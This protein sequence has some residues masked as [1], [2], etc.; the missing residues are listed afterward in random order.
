MR[1][2][3]TRK[4]MVT[5]TFNLL[6]AAACLLSWEAVA[7]ESSACPKAS[8]G[9]QRGQ[10]GSGDRLIGPWGSAA[11]PIFEPFCRKKSAPPSL[12]YITTL[13]TG[14]HHKPQGDT[15]A[16]QGRQKSETPGVCPMS[17][18]HYSLHSSPCSS[19]SPSS[20]P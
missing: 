3:C 11:K 18:P 1:W 19:L 12:P 13:V 15:I 5:A 17:P 4:T 10:G 14:S 2:K 6:G 9:E 16:A 8:G 7:D 20:V